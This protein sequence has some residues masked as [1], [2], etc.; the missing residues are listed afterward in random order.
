MSAQPA[1]TAAEEPVAMPEISDDLVDT[2]LRHY[3]DDS[4][5]AIRE[6]LADAAHLR[7]ELYTASCL[8]SR[9]IGRGWQPKYERVR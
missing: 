3:D 6:L 4:R 5:T 1:T 7:G 8:M 2:V 9:G